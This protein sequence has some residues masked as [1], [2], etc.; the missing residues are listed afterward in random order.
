MPFMKLK[1]NL[2]KARKIADELS[3]LPSKKTSFSKKAYLSL[4]DQL[5]I[6]NNAIPHLVAEAGAPMVLKRKEVPK[7]ETAQISTTSGIITI[8]KKDKQKFLADL[9][10]GEEALT[11][12]KKKQK[13]AEPK[14]DVFRKPSRYVA[15]ACSMFGNLSYKLSE[16]EIFLHL[17]KNLK[18]A[19]FPFLLP[20]YISISLFTTFLALII[21]VPIALLSSFFPVK[22]SPWGVLPPFTVSIAE[23]NTA[24][25]ASALKNL[26][27]ALGFSIA[28]FAF[29]LT[30][31][32]AQA[33]T[34]KRKI[35]NELPFA[36]MHMSAIAGSGVTP[37][38]VIR[39][40]ALSREYPFISKEAKKII[41]Q[42][43]FYGYNL[44]NSLHN[45]ARTCPHPVLAD[46]FNGMATTISSG[47]NLQL[48]LNK[49]AKD[50]LDDYRLARK[51]YTSLAETY[52]DIY[53]GLLI[54]APLIF[55]LMMVII[56]AIGGGI[57]GMS[58]QTLSL[59]G[60]VGIVLLN[61]GFLIFLQASQPEM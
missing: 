23:I 12:L 50:T 18:K 45:A 42:I 43:N 54:A 41:N 4:L 29:V 59:V 3:M 53:T 24:L 1:A 32:P 31:P 26:A 36:V 5:E 16:K 44:V 30:I 49:R 19:G 22:F 38:K 58:T 17:K 6:I 40:I 25:L 61:I 21:S 9:Q 7:P 55:M 46:I 2:E 47:G 20:T 57:A 8:S 15:A 56:N 13:A 51:K 37:V 39:I 33:S 52:A 11:L 28:C 35:S 60:I 34:I 27:I 48:Y 10:I 14:I